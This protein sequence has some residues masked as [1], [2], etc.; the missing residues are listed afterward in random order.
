MRL[1]SCSPTCNLWSIVRHLQR[2]LGGKGEGRLS[3]MSRKSA[4]QPLQDQDRGAV[5]PPVFFHRARR[6]RTKTPGLT[7]SFR[8]PLRPRRG[9]VGAFASLT[10][11]RATCSAPSSYAT[12]GPQN[13]SNS[14]ASLLSLNLQR[15]LN[16]ATY[17]RPV[18]HELKRTARAGGCCPS[19]PQE[20]V[21][22][23]SQDRS[24]IQVIIHLL[25][26]LE[27]V[28]SPGCLKRA[29]ATA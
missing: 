20:A 16:P 26:D 17:S 11:G 4:E 28:L 10:F 12:R 19:L 5:T 7:S 2:K 13:I 27:H 14:Q 8:E 23:Y 24:L 9:D 18:S 22:H 15:S 29:G 6:W 1:T 25:D 3:Q 21:L